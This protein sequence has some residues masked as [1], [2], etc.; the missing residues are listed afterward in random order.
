MTVHTK[1]VHPDY[2]AYVLGALSLIELAAKHGLEWIGIQE[3]IFN[4]NLGG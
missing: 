2:T 4:E 1:Q 3:K